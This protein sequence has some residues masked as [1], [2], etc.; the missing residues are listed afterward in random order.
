MILKNKKKTKSSQKKVVG[1]YLPLPLVQQLALYAIVV[2]G[3]PSTVIEELVSEKMQS[4]NLSKEKLIDAVADCL[5]RSWLVYTKE[6]PK[7][8][9]KT[10]LKSVETELVKKML[11]EDT[12]KQI[13]EKI[14]K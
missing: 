11:D 14:N 8:S 5:V 10:F 2:E 3:S 1:A 9:Y 6:F 12:V 7:K 13:I 4:N